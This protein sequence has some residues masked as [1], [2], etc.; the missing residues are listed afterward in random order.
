MRQNAVNKFAGNEKDF[1]FVHQTIQTMPNCT[2]TP[3]PVLVFMNITG[4][5]VTIQFKKYRKQYSEV[6]PEISY[7]LFYSQVPLAYFNEFI[8]NK[9]KNTKV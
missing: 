7:G 2:F 1:I 9:Y 4:I 8:K 6:P 3:N 5:T